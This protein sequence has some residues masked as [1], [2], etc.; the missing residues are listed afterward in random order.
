[1]MMRHIEVVVEESCVY[2]RSFYDC[3]LKNITSQL[4]QL[5]M[6]MPNSN[7]IQKRRQKNIQ[8]FYLN[9]LSSSVALYWEGIS[10]KAESANSASFLDRSVFFDIISVKFTNCTRQSKRD[11]EKSSLASLKA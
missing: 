3:C 7:P 6:K 2:R 5:H 9:I 11:K 10:I 8:H 4:K 1:M